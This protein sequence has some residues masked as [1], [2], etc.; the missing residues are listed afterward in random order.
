[1]LGTVTDLV[2]QTFQQWASAEYPD[3]EVAVT[4]LYMLAEALP[5]SMRSTLTSDLEWPLPVTPDLG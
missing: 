3:V 2:T 5:V 1:M 4:L